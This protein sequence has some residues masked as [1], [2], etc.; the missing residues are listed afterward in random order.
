MAV[1]AAVLAAAQ[2]AQAETRIL[3]RS[4]S[5][6]AFGGTTEKGNPVCG[7]SM[8]V[9]GRY[10]GVKYF[11]GEPSFTIQMGTGAWKVTNG[12]KIRVL[13][14]F[15]ARSPWDATATGMH[16]S[17][18]DA[19]VEFDIRQGELDNFLS[20]FR[21]SSRLRL[22]FPNR[23]VADWQLELTGVNAV[24]GAMQECVS[25]LKK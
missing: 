19:G 10:F 22:E 14:T 25:R 3:E 7:V 1:L 18:G 21:G 24:S 12:E 15:D 2:L 4:G 23:G 13:M 6:K 20:E 8:D 16:F 17:D 5:W 11:A 9:G